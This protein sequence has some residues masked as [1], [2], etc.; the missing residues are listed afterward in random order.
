MKLSFPLPLMVYISLLSAV[1]I[2]QTSAVNVTD[3]VKAGQ[4]EIDICGGC[5]HGGLC[6]RDVQACIC[7]PGF[8]GNHCERAV[9][10]RTP[11]FYNCKTDGGCQ[12][13]GICVETGECLCIRPYFGDQCQK[14]DDWWNASLDKEKDKRSMIVSASFAVVVMF[15]I[16]FLILY[17]NIKRV[18]EARDDANEI[19]N[20][21][22]VDGPPRMRR[23][24]HVNSNHVADDVET[25]S[26]REGSSSSVYRPSWY[27]PFERS[28]GR[29]ISHSREGITGLKAVSTAPAILQGSAP[30]K[31]G[32]V[33]N[34]DIDRRV[35]VATVHEADFFLVPPSYDEA[36]KGFDNEDGR[37]DSSV[38]GIFMRS[39]PGEDNAE[40]NTEQQN[41]HNSRL[42]SR[43]LRSSAHIKTTP[44]KIEEESDENDSVFEYH[45]EE[46][47]LSDGDDIDETHGVRE[48]GFSLRDMSNEDALAFVRQNLSCRS[49]SSIKEEDD[50]INVP[51]AIVEDD[52]VS[53]RL[54]DETELMQ[55]TTAL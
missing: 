51:L 47:N 49:R 41:E 24:P 54:N 15:I 38:S 16:C 40:D 22:Q 10:L 28:A 13:D 26:V 8:Q 12:H 17:I 3:E 1:I 27:L 7:T 25:A 35:S 52:D 50:A 30:P 23:P 9:H 39:I 48:R 19:R 6:D 36:A 29:R 34:E 20:A 14:V 37:R 5:K 33:T 42:N 43:R 55:R 45:H 21:I 32:D 46:N 4:Q 2:H 18:K 31:Y 44:P 53:V 11:I